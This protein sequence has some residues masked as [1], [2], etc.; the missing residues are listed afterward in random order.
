MKNSKDTQLSDRLAAAA[1]AKAALLNAYREA[2]AAAAPA[3]AARLAERAAIAAAREERRLERER[4]KLEER[5]VLHVDDDVQVAARAA[6]RAG[7]AFAAQA[8]ALTGRDA[9][10]GRGKQKGQASRPALLG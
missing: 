7:F 10:S 6:H 8:E 9:Q 4:V 5:M 1:E 3:K 2:H